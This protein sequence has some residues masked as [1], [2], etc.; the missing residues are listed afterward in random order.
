MQAPSTS[1]AEHSLHEREWIPIN[2]EVSTS[3]PHLPNSQ[4]TPRRP[5]L[6][7]RTHYAIETA[8]IPRLEQSF[9][10]QENEHTGLGISPTHI[11][12]ANLNSQKRAYRQRRKDP[13]CDACRER[14]VKCDATETAACSEC[15]SRNCKCQFTKE[16][17]GRVSA[18]PD[19]WTS[20]ITQVQDLQRQVAELNQQ[21]FSDPGL[22]RASSSWSAKDDETLIQARAQ[23]LNWNQI[24]MKHFLQKTPNAC[25]RRH[26]RLVER[27]NAEQWCSSIKLAPD[28][29]RS[30]TP[31]GRTSPP[32]EL[33]HPQESQSVS[34]DASVSNSYPGQPSSPIRHSDVLAVAP[35]DGPPTEHPESP[36]AFLMETAERSAPSRGS[37]SP[38][39]RSK[40]P[41][42]PPTGFDIEFTPQ[43]LPPQ[44]RP[45][46]Q[47][48]ERHSPSALASLPEQNR[49]PPEASISRDVRPKYG[50]DVACAR[51]RKRKI[52][53]GGDPGDGSGC[54]ACKLVDAHAKKCQFNRRV[55]LPLKDTTA[56]VG[57][58]GSLSPPTPLTAEELHHFPYWQSNNVLRNHPGADDMW[59]DSSPGTDDAASLD[60]V[61]ESV[62]TPEN[63]TYE[64]LPPSIRRAEELAAD[65][66]RLK[67]AG[68]SESV[69]VDAFKKENGASK[70]DEG[71]V[72]ASSDGSTHD[73]KESTLEALSDISDLSR[74]G[75]LPSET[76]FTLSISSPHPP[77]LSI[78]RAPPI[79]L[80]RGGPF[81]PSV[82]EREPGFGT[83]SALRPP[84]QAS[85]F[86]K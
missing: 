49:A 6:Q 36:F 15:L 70:P 85:I 19:R 20:V 22:D 25:R 48:D 53:C 28:W 32:L 4:Q 71:E 51:C 26:E 73:E 61:S 58:V 83:N 35:S 50:I 81:R 84:F 78:E 7:T 5:D 43:L 17:N 23:G 33:F 39:N 74:G 9:D 72:A 29:I 11:S 55:G 1:T 2:A 80:E 45:E 69:E 62:K 46:A 41:Q 3:P 77:P 56:D 52:R 14:K 27:Q 13:S 12:S 37:L 79:T 47:P 86:R 44:Q 34:S 24:A 63:S 57:Q 59:Q 67:P 16:T 30:Q 65:I 40:S 10:T 42:G 54:R 75:L 8:N 76:R 60:N 82:Y 21:A 18:I 38:G 66:D 64:C 31:P 68:T